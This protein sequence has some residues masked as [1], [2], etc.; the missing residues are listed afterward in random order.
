ME[1]PVVSGKSC[2]ISRLSLG[3]F[4]L[5]GW[6]PTDKN[7][8]CEFCMWIRCMWIYFFK[9]IKIQLQ[10]MMEDG[11]YLWQDEGSQVG[12]EMVECLAWSCSWWEYSRS[13]RDPWESY[14]ANYYSKVSDSS[15]CWI[16]NKSALH[17]LKIT[18]CISLTPKAEHIR[19]VVAPFGNWVCLKTKGWTSNFCCHNS[20]LVFLQV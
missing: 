1:F 17:D 18:S 10:N 3:D 20:V 14:R 15:M 11:H 19:H 5:N 16:F 4:N 8:V 6:R 12:T 13:V 2:K 9:K 7:I